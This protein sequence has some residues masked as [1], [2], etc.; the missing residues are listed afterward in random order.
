[1]WVSTILRT[2][3]GHIVSTATVEEST[4]VVLGFRVP[5][6]WSLFTEQSK[7]G[8]VGLLG[9]FSS[10]RLSIYVIV[11]FAFMPSLYDSI[12]FSRAVHVLA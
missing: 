3:I 2:V 5:L 8:G 6:A 11:H 4:K 1:M 10:D 7:S 12:R 9:P